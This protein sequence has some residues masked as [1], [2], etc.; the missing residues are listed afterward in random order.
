MGGANFLAKSFPP[1][2]SCLNSLQSNILTSKCWSV[3][4][5]WLT[6]CFGLRVKKRCRNSIVC[7]GAGCQR[8]AQ[9]LRL[10]LS[11]SVSIVLSASFLFLL[12]RD[13]T[14]GR[15]L[16]RYRLIFPPVRLHSKGQATRPP[17]Y[18]YEINGLHWI[19]IRPVRPIRLLVS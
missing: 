18:L 12:S 7:L 1:T 8:P 10:S 11:I 14:D 13:T 2:Y 19:T 16:S 4:S 5:S 6:I 17:T 9:I 15:L 3:N